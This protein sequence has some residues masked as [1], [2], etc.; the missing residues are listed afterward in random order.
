MAKRAPEQPAGANP[1]AL[2]AHCVNRVLGAGQSLRQAAP[3]DSALARELSYG[4]LRYAP[5][6]RALLDLLLAKPLPRTDGEIGALL[7]IGMYQLSHTRI[8]A[9]A[10]INET[11]AACGPLGKPYARPLVNGVLRNYQRRGDALNARL[12]GAERDAHPPWLH[13]AL[14]AHWP[15]Q[16]ASIIAAN[17][18]RPPMTLRVNRRHYSRSGY[19]AQLRAAGIAAQPCAL[20][21]HG[22]TLE[23][24]VSV[25]ALPRFADGAVSVQDASAQLAAPLLRLG[26]GLRLL[27]ACAAPGGKLAHCLERAPGLSACSALD[28]SA[29][30]LAQLREGLSRLRLDDASLA[31]TS[32]DAAKL[33]HWWDGQA[34]HR[35]MLD[36]PCSGSGIIRRHPDIKT[37]RQEADIAAL[38]RTQRRL[39]AA[40]WRCV[41]PGGLLLYS[42]CSVL[43]AEGDAL[44]ADFVERRDDVRCVAL[45]G[46]WGVAQRCGRQRL[47]TPDGGDGF[48]YALLRRISDAP[49]PA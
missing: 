10:A 42:V 44:V 26:P 20:A 2:A 34:Y 47:P 18:A 49:I 33:N 17:N 12:S 4:A 13:R 5:R 24:P 30:R 37:L 45:S 15:E 46:R 8:P 6:L 19:L 1:R 14:H 9:H 21:P 29:G 3:V 32:C 39:L 28:Q 38:A 36:A 40:L 31:L 25:R 41:A 35:V 11:V 16:A 48:Y 27:D 22:V 43:P 7:L 23:T